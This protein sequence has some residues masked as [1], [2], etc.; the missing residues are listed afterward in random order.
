MCLGRRHA[1]RAKLLRPRS[2]MVTGPLR[3]WSGTT[4]RRRGPSRINSLGRRGRRGRRGRALVQVPPRRLPCPERRPR[5]RRNTHR[6]GLLRPGQ[7][8]R[9]AADGRW[10]ARRRLERPLPPPRRAA[11][12]PRSPTP[13]TAAQSGERPPS[14]SEATQP[15]GMGELDTKGLGVEWMTWPREA[16]MAPGRIHSQRK[17]LSGKARTAPSRWRCPHTA[18]PR[19]SAS[20]AWL[21]SRVRRAMDLRDSTTRRREP[22]RTGDRIRQALAPAE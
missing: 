6:T 10:P 9:V 17:S 7:D 15:R 12:S 14:Q 5:D 20:T 3:S 16:A 18:C 4:R 2:G 13:L 19:Q 11:T 21:G 8:R 22:P 1:D